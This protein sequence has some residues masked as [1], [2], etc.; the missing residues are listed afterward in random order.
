[1]KA[2]L[3]ASMLIL[4]VSGIYACSDN[5]CEVAD[6]STGCLAISEDGGGIDEKLA[7][8]EG[9]SEFTVCSTSSLSA[10]ICASSHGYLMC[11]KECV[12]FNDNCNPGECRYMGNNASGSII[13][14]MPEGGGVAIGGACQYQTD[15]D[16]G[17]Q[18]VELSGKPK[19]C[20]AVCSETVPCSGATC[21]DTGFGFSICAS[22]T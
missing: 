11:V 5:S 14:C 8:C 19:T 21:T 1:M 2:I 6:G 10:G 22:G 9:K 16:K 4:A 20:Y 13:A 12:D 18:C 17:A 15:C 3:F 7:H